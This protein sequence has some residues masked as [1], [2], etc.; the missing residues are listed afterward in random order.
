MQVTITIKDLAKRLNLSPSTVS[1]ALKDHYSIGEDTKRAVRALALELNY[2]PNRAALSLL[3]KKSSIIGVV[4][5]NITTSFYSY[6]ISGV[7]EVCL[8]NNYQ[9]IFSQSHEKLENEKKA[10]EILL[11][12]RVDGMIVALSRETTTDEHLIN[13]INTGKSLILVDR[14]I[15]NFPCN[16]IIVDDV[17]GTEEATDFLISKGCRRIAY[18]A[19]FSSLFNDQQRRKG[20]LNSLQKNNIETSATYICE[21]GLSPNNLRSFFSKFAKSEFPDGIITY[22]DYIAFEAMKEA[23]ARCLKI[24]EDVSI[25]GFANEPICLHVSPLL[26]TIDQPAFEMG[27]LAAEQ[28]L[29]DIKKKK[30]SDFS[31]RILPTRIILR[32]STKNS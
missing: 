3:N 17:K 24:P 19:G 8:K 25:F 29:D 15:P 1:R 6:V 20:Y 28:L 14:V 21:D 26:S 18:L 10:L 12:A 5:P 2:K 16:K 32:D 9:V 7:E 13:V 27:K 22:N 11:D 23:K 31:T 4:I 30:T